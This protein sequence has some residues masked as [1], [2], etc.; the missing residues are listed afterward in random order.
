M[1]WII[2]CYD[3]VGEEK[4]DLRKCLNLTKPTTLRHSF[5]AEED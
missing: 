2:F 4:N 3:Y 1:N 5:Y